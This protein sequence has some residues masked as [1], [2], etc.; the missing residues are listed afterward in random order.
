[1]ARM[2]TKKRGKSASRKPIN[3]AAPWVTHSAE[4]VEAL[5]VKYAK[6]GNSEATIGRILRDV[7]AIPSI[8]L[9][10]GKTISQILT[11]KKLNPKYPSDLIDLIRRAVAVKK[12]M[13][14]N[15]R[16]LQNRIKL[17]HIEAK[18]KRLVKYYR[19]NKLPADWKYNPEKAELLVK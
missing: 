14:D 18:I 2:H 8:R 3:K 10:A 11:D 6:E 1:M 12:H 9:V 13:Q 15:S 5:V 17:G 7:H 19:G 4:D 16:D